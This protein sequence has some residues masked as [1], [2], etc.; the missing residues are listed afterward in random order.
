MKKIVCELCEGTVFDKVDGRF[1]CKSCG[2]SYSAE[3]ARDMMQE[4]EGDAPTPNGVQPTPVSTPQGNVNQQQL[5]NILVLATSA[6]E[7][8]NQAEAEN[9]CNQAIVIDAMCY[10]AW[11]LKG[12]A[13]GW[14]STLGNNRMEEAAHAFCKAIDFAP[15][16]EKE[17]LKDQAVNELKNLGLACISLRKDNFAKSPETSQLNGFKNDRLVLINALKVLLSHGNAVGM[18][19][20]Y[21]EEIASMMNQ[22]A[23]AALNM[24]RKVWAN[25]E[26]PGEKDWDTYVGWCSNIEQLIRQSIDAS[27]DDDEADIQRWKNLKIVL[28]EPMDAKSYHRVWSDWSRSYEWRVQYTMADSAKATRRRQMQECDDAIAKI[29]RD[30]KAKKEAELKKAQEEKQARLDAYWADPEHAEEKAKLDAEKAELTEKVNSLNKEVLDITNQINEA[31]RQ[32]KEATPSE[33]E[34]SKVQDQIR[35][36]NNERANLGMFQGGRKKEINNQIE[37]LEARVSSLK[38]KAQ[39]EKDAKKAEINQKLAPAHSKK[40][41]LETEISG[42]QKRISEINKRLTE[43]PAEE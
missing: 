16:E 34:L 2:T 23:V 29:E 19:E 33:T 28:E 35:D 3:E 4:V 30:L 8:S 25:C 18:P 38:E 7:A 9:Y 42:L 20:G 1:V 6:Y 5:D 15:E 24:V 17:S 21:L 14:Q 36:L 43:D 11:F 41:E 10:K 12:K 37:I 27:D 22:S 32:E 39:Q 31:N 40:R 13:V 26:H